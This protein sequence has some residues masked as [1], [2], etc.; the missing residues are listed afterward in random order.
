MKHFSLQRY[1]YS[2]T[3]VEKIGPDTCFKYEMS[4]EKLNDHESRITGTIDQLIELD[5]ENEIEFRTYHKP[6]QS[7]EY[8]ETDFH[9]LRKGVCEFLKGPYKYFIYKNL[10]DH[11][12]FPH[13]DTCPINKVGLI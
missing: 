11:S 3:K 10:H 8:D 12:N 1:R 7:D 5:D 13:Y 2:F 9:Y 4:I 6:D